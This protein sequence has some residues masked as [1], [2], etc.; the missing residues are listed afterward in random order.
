[1]TYRLSE[2]ICEQYTEKF[3]TYTLVL[4]ISILSKRSSILRTRKKKEY[5]FQ[6][7]VKY[8][9]SSKRRNA[10]LFRNNLEYRYNLHFLL[11]KIP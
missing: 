8:S 6:R 9:F 7:I 10:K 1:M 4:E 3:A 5:I 2:N 11:A